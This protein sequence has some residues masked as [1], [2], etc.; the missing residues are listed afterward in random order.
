M[1]ADL[2]EQSEHVTRRESRT[3]WR[4]KAPLHRSR[5]A[6]MK[7]GINPSGR[8]RRGVAANKG[9]PLTEG[10]KRINV[11]KQQQQQPKK[12]TRAFITNENT[13]RTQS[14]FLFLNVSS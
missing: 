8:S 12:S 9:E 14:L 6:E 7:K 2:L 1:E 13:S 4:I 10:G 11:F 3:D 5:Y